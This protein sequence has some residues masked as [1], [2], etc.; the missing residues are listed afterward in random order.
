MSILE[1]TCGFLAATIFWGIVAYASHLREKRNLRFTEKI[2]ERLKDRKATS[3]P[4]GDVEHYR[5][6]AK[7]IID[8]KMDDKLQTELL[9]RRHGLWV[10]GDGED[11]AS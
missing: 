1:F 11:G 7:D 8:D 10:P 4:I 6:D 9:R 5:L 2:F 3:N